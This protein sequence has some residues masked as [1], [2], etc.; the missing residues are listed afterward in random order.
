MRS[1]IENYGTPRYDTN[2]RII[3]YIT[4]V[5]SF[6]VV[7][8]RTN[9]ENLQIHFFV[10]LKMQIFK[11]KNFFYFQVKVWFQ[12]RRTKHKRMQQEDDGK[13]GNHSNSGN[14]GTR[15]SYDDDEDEMIDMEDCSDEYE[16]EHH[17]SHG[18]PH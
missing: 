1:S 18:L 17:Q 11:G 8:M 2:E 12:N 4:N 10:S 6:I 7:F 15:H 13:D 16:D 14:D 3:H 9:I 5:T